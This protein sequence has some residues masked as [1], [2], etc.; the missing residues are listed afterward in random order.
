MKSFATIVALAGLL[1]CLFSCDTGKSGPFTFTNNT[2]TKVYVLI[3]QDGVL[4]KEFTAGETYQGK[5]YFIPQITFVK[6]IDTAENKAI[7]DNRYTATTNN[8]FDYSF[9]KVKGTAIN[10]ILDLPKDLPPELTD[11]YLAETQGKLGDY[12][13][14]DIK[15]T[16][17]MSSPVSKQLYTDS[18]VFKI[19]N[20]AKQDVTD[21]FTIAVG[22]ESF[23]T[24]Q[25]NLGITYPKVEVVQN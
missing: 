9:V 24:V 5:D 8:G 12:S 13:N 1:C 3:D 11:C 16:S 18:P 17:G 6:E 15:L 25:W 23:P 10:I 14:P 19:Y 21:L 2:G 22:K 20:N 7:I 4:E